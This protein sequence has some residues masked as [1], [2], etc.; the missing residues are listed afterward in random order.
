MTEEKTEQAV[1]T[2]QAA[3]PEA[4]AETPA[5]NPL[6]RSL[7][8]SV[9]SAEVQ[10]LVKK[11]L[12]NYAKEARMP[13][14]RKGHVPAAQVEMMYGRQ[15]YDQAFNE[16]IGKAW[17]EAAQASG[18]NI[19]GQPTVTPVEGS[20]DD[21]SMKFKAT[22]EVFPEIECPD[23]KAV[24]LKRYTCTVDEAA[25]QK[26]L[27]VMRRQRANYVPAAEDRAAQKDDQVTVNFR[28]TKDGEEFA[29]GKAEGFKFVIGDGRML[30]DFDTAVNG[31]KKGEKKTFDMTFPENYGPAELNGATVQFEVELTDLQVAELPELDDEF[32]RSLGVE[33][34]VEKMIADVRSNLEREV[35]ARIT[36]K[37]EKEAFDVLA[38]TL[39]FPVPTVVVEEERKNMCNDFAQSMKQRGMKDVPE[40]PA[41]MFKEEAEKRVRNGMFLSFIVEQQK[42]QP[43]EEQITERAK[44]IAGSYEAPDEVVKYLTTDRQRRAAISA[45][46]VQKN[47]CDWL[48]GQATTTDEAVEF[49]K[50]MSG[51]F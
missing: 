37:T 29:G 10:A 50:V 47:F 44:L 42:L 20:Q 15:A 45:Q 25:V 48:L 18:L 46:V 2:E 51:A 32:A 36:Q 8:L 30:A 14:F 38:D 23:L 3:A 19:A 39:K 33:G 16:L 40:F 1:E 13:G 5:V 7:E 28:G 21:E 26:T 12:R 34:G 11:Y 24:A 17:A 35:E 49:D 9:S 6:E 27:D 31:M 43:S 22:F 4:A 41:E